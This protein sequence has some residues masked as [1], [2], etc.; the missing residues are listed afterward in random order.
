[1]VRVESWGLEAVDFDKIWIKAN[2]K[3]GNETSKERFNEFVNKMK[4]SDFED[5]V[6]VDVVSFGEERSSVDWNQLTIL[7]D[8]HS[9]VAKIFK[10]WVPDC[11]NSNRIR[12]V[13]SPS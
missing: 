12:S 3:K 7:A 2:L 5:L 13:P 6:E 11:I 8:Q 4:L 10:E 9:Y 1:G